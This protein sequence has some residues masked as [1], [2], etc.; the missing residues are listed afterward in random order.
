MHE[1]LR[2]NVGRLHFAGE[3]TSTEL[4]GFL[5]GAWFEGKN[6]ANQIAA[7]LGAKVNASCMEDDVHYDVLHGTSPPR[8]YS[9][10]NGW[11]FPSNLTYGDD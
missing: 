8:D 11:L 5:H 9:P 2:A 10:T 6:K 1:N 3:A 7:C 4:Y